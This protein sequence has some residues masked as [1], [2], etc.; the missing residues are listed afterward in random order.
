MRERPNQFDFTYAVKHSH[1][2]LPV[3]KHIDSFGHTLINYT[4]LTEPMDTVGKVRIREGR[5]QT[6]PPRLMLPDDFIQQELEGFGK[7]ASRYMDFIRE[8][9]KELKILNYSYRLRKEAFSCTDVTDSIETVQDR[10]KT[11]LEARKDPY[12]ALIIG[13]EE[14]WDVSVLQL[15]VKTVELS[16]PSNIRDLQNRANQSIL[17]RQVP[18]AVKVEI[19]IAFKAAQEDKSLVQPLGLLLKKHGLFQQ[20]EDRF[21]ALL[22]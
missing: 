13:V 4:L 16:V 18:R 19:E 5:L 3:T 17:K 9:Q 7:E 21:F 8:H 2:I 10:V 6:Y 14:P 20:Y 15:F 1:I 22:S 12:S 11:A